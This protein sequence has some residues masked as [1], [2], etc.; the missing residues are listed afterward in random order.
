[1]LALLRDAVLAGGATMPHPTDPAILQLARCVNAY[2]QMVRGWAGPWREEE[3]RRRKIS[4]A[5]RVLAENLPAERKGF[6]VMPAILEQYASMEQAAKARATLAAFDALVT[7][8]REASDRGLPQA[9]VRDPSEPW[10]ERWKDFAERMTDIFHE[11]L[12]GHSK[13]AAYRFIVAVTPAI[14][15][16]RPTFQAVEAHLKKRRQVNRGKRRGRL[17]LGQTPELVSPIDRGNGA[18]HIAIRPAQRSASDGFPNP[19]QPR[20]AAAS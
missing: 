3:T 14:T 6:A 17:P 1:V 15:G 2:R 4:E 20:R 16:E 8:A 11:V 9:F 19:R 13:A 18:S 10:P 5:I 7:A 12:P